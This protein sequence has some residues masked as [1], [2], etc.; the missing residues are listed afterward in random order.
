M[1]RR[2]LPSCPWSGGLS[3]R[4]ACRGALR[5]SP[6]H[7]RRWLSAQIPFGIDLVDELLPRGLTQEQVEAL[8]DYTASPAL[9]TAIR[10]HQLTPAVR[11]WIQ[12]I[13]SAMTPTSVTIRATRVIVA[14]TTYTAWRVHSPQDVGRL[15]GE[16]IEEDGYVSVCITP[17][18]PADIVRSVTADQRLVIEFIVP[19]RTM[20]VYLEPVTAH[21]GEHELLPMRGAR[22]VILDEPGFVST[23]AGW[24]MTPII[25]PRGVV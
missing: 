16:L 21:R 2:T 6:A 19:H 5:R 7:R 18:P 10:T 8:T 3:A 20:A 22:Y 4:S 17:S 24:R 1:D 25:D 23:H 9:N 15:A 13:D 12:R 11:R 14:S